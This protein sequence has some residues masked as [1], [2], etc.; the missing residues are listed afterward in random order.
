MVLADGKH[1]LAFLDPAHFHA[2]LT[3]RMPH[4]RLDEEVHVYGSDET[5]VARFLALIEGFNARDETP[6]RWRPRVHMGA[7]A[8][9]R[10]CAERAADAVVLA[11][12][13]DPPAHPPHGKSFTFSLPSRS[14]SPLMEYSLTPN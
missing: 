10:L 9:A 5:E 13:R 4:P 1:R 2:A 3:L 12:L 7:D 14:D 6:T 11:S 8:L